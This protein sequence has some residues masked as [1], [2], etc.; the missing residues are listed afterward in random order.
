MDM[1]VCACV[2]HG[3]GISAFWVPISM[4][5]KRLFRTFLSPL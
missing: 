5:I 3:E 2:Q 4:I 1:N